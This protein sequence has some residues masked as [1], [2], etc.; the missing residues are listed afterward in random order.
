VQARR[1]IKSVQLNQLYTFL[2][3]HP[4]KR[5]CSIPRQLP[6]FR[7]IPKA[8]DSAQYGPMSESPVTHRAPGRLRL[9]DMVVA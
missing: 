5:V 9:A 2:D 6:G 8:D 7:P 1:Q 3:R 4:A